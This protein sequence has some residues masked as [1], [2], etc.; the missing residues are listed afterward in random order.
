[1]RRLPCAVLI[2]DCH[3]PYA[4]K[5]AWGLVM[6]A[7]TF[8][9]PQTVAVL[10]DFGD[11]YCLSRFLRDPNRAHALET[12]VGACNGALDELDAACARAGTDDKRFLLGN[13]EARLE[14]YL[15]EKA[16]ELFNVVSVP[17]L[18]RL[19]ARDYRVTAYGDFDRIGKLLITH[20]VGFSGKDAHR[21]SSAETGTNTAIGH[22]L[23]VAYE[24][25]TINRGFVPLSEITRNDIAACYHDGRVVSSPILDVVRYRYSGEMAVFQKQAIRQRM[26]DKHHLFAKDGRYLPVRH[27][28]ETLAPKDLVRSCRPLESRAPV[29]ISDA[30]LRLV[31]A[32]CADGSKASEGSIRFHLKKARKIER[33]TDL[34]NE[35]GGAV[36]WGKP[37]KNG[38]RKTKKLSR[39]IQHE[40]IRLC[41]RKQ[42]PPWILD[43]SPRQ[44]SIII[45]ELPLWDGSTLRIAGKD[46]GSR[47]FSSAKSEERDL[48]QRLLMLNGRR[49]QLSEDVVSFNVKKLTST[50]SHLL[51]NYVRWE[52]VENED[53]GCITTQYNNFF[54]RTP[55]G[56]VE[57]TGNTHQLAVSYSS[58]VLGRH[59]VA[60]M[61][62]W[63]GDASKADYLHR[64]KKTRDWHLGFGIAYLMSDGV[65]HLTPVP[66]VNYTCVIE[67]KLLR[68]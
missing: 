46:Y 67:G 58:N 6:R 62:G 19:K 11:F 17:E 15:A 3:W 38:E 56:S 47:Q 64:A 22:C 39:P 60:A 31:V 24:V 28:I 41:P 43:L 34:I 8:L 42:L 66:I 59:N 50:D 44:R 51:R 13:H 53:V 20:D 21:R 54:I 18:F 2:P 49:S 45:D 23:P 68:G 35:A 5:R 55:G 61:L 26:T 37:G 48:V 4:D 1:M 16:P 36:A 9:K 33:L 29:P 7:I 30:M 14:K 65:T 57:L 40:L 32:Y 25:L 52:S 27:A 12:E 63:L 10:G